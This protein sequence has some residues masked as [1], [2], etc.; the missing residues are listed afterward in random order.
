LLGGLI[1]RLVVE[2]ESFERE[3]RLADLFA[4]PPSIQFELKEDVSYSPW[5][6]RLRDI[7]VET[8]WSSL[9]VIS[10]MDDSSNA[11]RFAA[12][13]NHIILV[14]ADREVQTVVAES[15]QKLVTNP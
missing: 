14:E 10:P 11:T 6:C 3:Q 1:E 5:I 15:A 9:C 4:L 7:R 13:T 8:F 2:S 12:E